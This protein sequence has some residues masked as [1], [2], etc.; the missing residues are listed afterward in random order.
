M[1][2][3]A[4]LIDSNLHMNGKSVKIIR[5]PTGLEELVSENRA[6]HNVA[7]NYERVCRAYGPERVAATVETVKQKEQAEK[8]QKR[9]VRHRQ[10]RVSR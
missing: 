9:I 7:D 10:D 4:N 3:L 2:W 5:S 8:E 6:L 1:I